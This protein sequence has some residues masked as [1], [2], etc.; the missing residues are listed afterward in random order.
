L[1]AEKADPFHIFESWKSWPISVIF[2]NI[3]KWD[4]V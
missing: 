4:R 3:G 2:C 1:K